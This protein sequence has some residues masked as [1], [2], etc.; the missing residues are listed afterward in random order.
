MDVWE[1]PQSSCS[2]LDKGFLMDG[3]PQRADDFGL[4]A[5]VEMTDARGHYDVR[6]P[7]PANHQEEECPEHGPRP[8]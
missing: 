1:V 2:G 6:T 4:G 8:Q 5:L 3:G 7:A